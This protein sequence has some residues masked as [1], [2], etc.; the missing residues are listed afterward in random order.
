MFYYE[1]YLPIEKDEFH[2]N[3]YIKFIESRKLRNFP[4]DSYIEKHHIIPKS[5]LPK[6]WSRK[7]KYENN[8]IILTGRE[9]FIVHLILWKALDYKMVYAFH[10]MINSKGQNG[11]ISKLTSKQYEHLKLD[12]SVNHSKNMRS[13]VIMHHP[14]SEKFCVRIKKKEVS[15]Y[16]LKGY[17]IGTNANYICTHSGHSEE[18]KKRLSEIQKTKR[19]KNSPHFGHK[20]SQKTKY[21]MSKLKKD[22]IWVYNRG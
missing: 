14:E 1:N 11:S 5:Y 6:N 12:K 16:L 4:I 13:R 10:K 15:F 9:H 2:W 21:R 20:H 19:G 18:T 17:L 22:L 3:C 7:K 8:F